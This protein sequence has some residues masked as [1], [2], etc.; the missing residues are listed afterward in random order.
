MPNVYAY[1]L[2]PSGIDRVSQLLKDNQIAIGWSDLDE[3]TALSPSVSKEE[4]RQKLTALYPQL[5]AKNRITYGTNQVW[6]FTQE[7]KVGDI[8]IV[9]HFGDAHFLRVTG[10]PTYLAHKVKD[11]TAI[12]RE[13][14]KLKTVKRLDLPSQI[15]QGLVFRG[16]ASVSLDHI[17]HEVLNFLGIDPEILAE[18]EEAVRAEKLMHEAM[19]AYAIPAKDEITVTRRHA[20]VFAALVEH[21][22]AKGL[23][24]VNTRTAGL[25]PDL[26]TVC[27]T[28]PMLFEIKTGQGSGDY[29][30]ALGQLLF[31][32]KVRGRSY[33]KFLV[34]PAGMGQLA[35]SI[36]A[37]F[38]IGVIEYAT[39]DGSLSFNWPCVASL[40]HR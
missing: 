39:Q 30:K 40:K 31:Y 37:G 28:D 16:H 18:E 4:I 23:K 36:L 6:R 25:A 17:K 22:Q 21:L 8:V 20:D 35:I 29:L 3:Q 5:T 13:I 2:A 38:Y 32:E 12:R 10:E 11:D 7:V 34:A 14:R 15:R 27:T 24:V 1:R 33:R 26:C 9:P 19:G